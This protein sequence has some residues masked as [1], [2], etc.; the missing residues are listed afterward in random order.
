MSLLA[1]SPLRR[2]FAWFAIGAALIVPQ[3]AWSQSTPEPERETAP[4]SVAADP[5]DELVDAAIASAAR[6]YLNAEQHT[7]W[8]IMHG[9]LA[10]R[11]DYQ[12]RK[13]GEKI[14][15]LEWLA[16]GPRFEGRPWFEK[17]AVG[18]RA[19]PY[20][21][22]YIFEGHPNQFLAILTM[23]DLPLD[24]R[25]A[26]PD[27]EITIAD[28]VK[29]AQWEVTTLEEPTWTLWALSHYLDPDAT[30]ENKYQQQWSLGSLV[31][32]QVNESFERAACGGTHAGFALA[33]ALEKYRETGRPLTGAWLEADQ[34]VRRYVQTARAYQNSDGSLSTSYFQS[35]THS[36]DF[37]TRVQTSGH[38]LEFV[39]AALP[40]E[41]LREDWVRR[42][43]HALARDIYEQRR[44]PVDVGAL[45]HAVDALV[46][47]RDRTR[48]AA[49]DEAL[50]GESAPS[51]IAP[52]AGESESPAAEGP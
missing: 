24:F 40:A 2:L 1:G 39:V 28:M 30:W 6:R 34:K 14:N 17:T 42:A 48:A 21:R 29:H 43:V 16:T 26:T 9:L 38:T 18:G 32:L 3:Q 10:L 52:T 22:N 27:G 4:A 15:A 12:I 20:T 41:Q 19:Q 13:D 8:Q 49:R 36:H 45:F 5:L 23:S 44:A 37:A 7:P 47:Y 51:D 50:A 11:R 33:R 46:I 35:R 31:R 25:L